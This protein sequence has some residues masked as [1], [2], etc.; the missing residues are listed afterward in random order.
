M[1]RKRECEARARQGER[2]GAR[3]RALAEERGIGKLK[4]KEEIAEE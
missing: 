3:A 2:D 1:R 4:E